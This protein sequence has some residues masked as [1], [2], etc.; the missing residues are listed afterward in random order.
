MDERKYWHMG[1]PSSEK[2]DEQPRLIN[3]TWLDVASY[4]EDA[5]AFG[6][7]DQT[8]ER[9]VVRWKVLLEKARRHT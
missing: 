3:G 9:L 8:L 2:P 4:R 5:R 7:D 6:Y 1:N